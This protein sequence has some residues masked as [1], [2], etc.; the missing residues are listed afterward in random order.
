MCLC[1]SIS[2]LSN[3]SCI[4]IH[5]LNRMLEL[6]ARPTSPAVREQQVDPPPLKWPALKYGFEPE[7][8]R[9]GEEAHPTVVHVWTAP[10]AQGFFA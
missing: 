8:D 6:N 5:A 9:D 1:L 10:E 2:V 4:I 3:H 7:E